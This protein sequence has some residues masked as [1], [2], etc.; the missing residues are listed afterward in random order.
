MQLFV[1]GF[2]TVEPFEVLPTATIAEV[3]AQIA[4]AHG[5]NCDDITL[6]CEG[7]ALCNDTE[8]A[9]FTAFNN[10]KTFNNDSQELCVTH[11]NYSFT[12]FTFFYI[13]ECHNPL[14]K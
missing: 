3:K 8:L 7:N 9:L 10:N 11:F 1:R 6:N 2:D 13:T 5:L 14:C 4:Q 12:K